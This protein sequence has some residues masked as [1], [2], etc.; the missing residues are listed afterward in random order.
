MAK[1]TRTAKPTH[2]EFVFWVQKA[3]SRYAFGLS[4]DRR[5][6]DLFEEDI[7]VTLVA[8]C[9]YPDRFKGRLADIRLSEGPELA[10]LNS[11]RSE[12]LHPSAG[13]LHIT[14]S[15]FEIWSNL[16]DRACWRVADSIANGTITSMLLHGPVLVRGKAHLTSISFHGPDFD[17]IAYVG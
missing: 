6:D 17:P 11:R 4:H 10:A 16:P 5:N 9:I 13:F 12:P 2:E 1:R 3:S 14:P 15:V 8:E 7:T